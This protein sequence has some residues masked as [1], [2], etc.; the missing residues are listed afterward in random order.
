MSAMRG[1][2]SSSTGSG[3]GPRAHAIEARDEAIMSYLEQH[4]AREKP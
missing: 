1:A 4:G 2:L 3:S